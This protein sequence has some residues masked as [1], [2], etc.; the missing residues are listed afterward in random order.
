MFVT[1]G[2]KVIKSEEVVAALLKMEHRPLPEWKKEKPI[3]TRQLAALLE[4]FEIAPNSIGSREKI[5]AAIT[6]ISSRMPA[7]DTSAG[8]IPSQKPLPEAL[9][10]LDR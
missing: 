6:S 10:P 3:T 8:S 7:R 9:L 1:K 2:E 4:P 5:G